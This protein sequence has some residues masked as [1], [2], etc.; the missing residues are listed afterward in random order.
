MLLKL[1]NIGKIY[2]SNDILTIGIRNI[3]LEFDYN[4][5][6]II[7]GESGAGKSTLLN[8]LAANDSY[9]EGELYFNGHETSHYS[10]SDWEKY[11][12]D[13]I[14]MIFQ[15]FNIIEN[16]TVLENVELALLRLEDKKERRRIA[17]DLIG[18]VG[19]SKQANQ[20]SS[21]LSG[22]E[23]QRCVIARALA[24]DSPIILADE[25][26]GN[27]DVNSSK[28]I[29]KLLKDVSKDKLV[30][31][32]TH[33][34]E[35]FVKYATREV[36]I[37]DGKVKD[38]KKLV[39]VCKSDITY[40][41]NI[42]PNSKKLDFKNMMHIG[43]LNYKS[44][45][46]FTLM[47][48][49]TLLICAIVLFLTVTVFASS[50]IESTKTTLDDIGIDGKV[51]VS[52]VDN[53]INQDDLDEVISKTKAGFYLL[54]RSDSLFDITIPRKG[55][56][57]RSYKI[58][59]LY[60][61]YEYNLDS[62]NA[63][64]VIAS[65]MKNDKDL[66]V[67]ALINAEIGLDN[68][69]VSES[70]NIDDV[71]LYLSASTLNNYAAKMKALYS[72]MKLGLDETIVYTFLISDELNSGEIE[73]VNSNFYQADTKVVTFDYKTDKLYTVIS[74]NKKMDDKSGLV[75]LM[76]SDDYNHMFE[77]ST[78]SVQSAIYFENDKI[79]KEAIKSL[80]DGYIAMLS[81][82][83]VYV[84]AASDIYTTNILYYIAL[85]AAS[86]LFSVLIS[87]IFMR[88]VKVFKADFA[89]YRTLGISRV[90]SSKSLYIQ[91]FLIFLPSILLLPLV[92]LIAT[93]IP[94]SFI[95]FIS[96]GNYLFVEVM[97]L[98]IV[99]VVAFGFNKSI[100]SKSILKSLSRGSK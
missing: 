62:G 89:V 88:S 81:T 72:N 10:E 29:A 57:S 7:T 39:E 58:N 94:G 87:I 85:I 30:I 68:I 86:I 41:E 75:V 32:V 20:K 14:A 56:L 46:K 19:L 51:I 50:L 34:P 38:D 26:T 27:L 15:D 65:S 77:N 43:T 74:S 82:S 91:M 24:K 90:V 33:N 31:V 42:K 11:R 78:E 25:P 67:S 47:M 1:D 16:L 95:K 70:L 36:V 84:N 53:S 45:P 64:L 69:E 98:L 9:E 5:F 63:V 92:S 8:V 35:Y 44:R 22:G 17:L 21:K 79:A 55:G 96:F 28:E 80:P 37:Y 59:M 3:N 54:N 48:S 2:N 23:K 76:N 61:P 60:S 13:Y 4:E 99:E 49:F 71:Y 100:N 40:D 12:E 18:K 6:V 93:I 97:L 73:L 83:K 52:N 66:L